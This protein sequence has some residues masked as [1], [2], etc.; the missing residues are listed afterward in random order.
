MSRHSIQTMIVT[1]ALVASLG[2]MA[3]GNGTLNRIVPGFSQS[4]VNALP[5]A[6]A[7]EDDADT[8]FYVR[9]SRAVWTR[10]GDWGF[11]LD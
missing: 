8:P 5:E 4:A 6:G 3:W 2:A 11:E 9:P 10:G 7:D 1:T